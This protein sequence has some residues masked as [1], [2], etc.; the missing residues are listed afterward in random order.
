MIDSLK[1][2]ILLILKNRKEW[3]MVSMLIFETLL[4]KTDWK[5]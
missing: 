5:K 4:N 1:T 3:C 2:K